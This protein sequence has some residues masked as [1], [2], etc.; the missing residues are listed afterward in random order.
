M[1]HSISVDHLTLLWNHSHPHWRCSLTE[2]SDWAM[3]RAKE[4]YHDEE[5]ARRAAPD[6]PA[7]VSDERERNRTYS[8][9]VDDTVGDRADGTGADRAGV[10]CLSL[11]LR[12][13]V[14]PQR[15]SMRGELPCA[16]R[17]H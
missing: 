2:R 7:G 5:D 11:V 10:G 13:E 17:R 12:I 4:V 14:V 1:P 16:V 9:R 3:V 15:L 6:L 8:G